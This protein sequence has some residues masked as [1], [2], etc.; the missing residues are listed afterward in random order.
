MV[1][2]GRG[3]WLSKRSQRHVLVLLAV[4]EP[5]GCGLKVSHVWRIWDE[6][7]RFEG[8]ITKSFQFQR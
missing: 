8:H 1:G 5:V 3:P 6:A 2:N 7:L 4:L